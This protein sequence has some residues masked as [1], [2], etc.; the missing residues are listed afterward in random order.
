LESYLDEANS[1]NSNTKRRIKMNI[2]KY[3]NQLAAQINA[4]EIYAAVS[5]DEDSKKLLRVAEKMKIELFRINPV[6]DEIDNMNDSELLTALR[7]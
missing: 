5:N 7:S 2:E 1:R 6:P 4:N 3:S